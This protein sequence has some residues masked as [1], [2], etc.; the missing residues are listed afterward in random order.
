MEQLLEQ[1]EKAGKADAPELEDGEIKAQ[2]L[3]DKRREAAEA[4]AEQKVNLLALLQ[5]QWQNSTATFL[6]AL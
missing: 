5:S 1:A 3:E 6:T 4:L 2:T